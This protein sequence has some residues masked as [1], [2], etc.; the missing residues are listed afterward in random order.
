MFDPLR[1]IAARCTC[2]LLGL[3][4]A[5]LVAPVSASQQG[6]LD[7][8]ARPAEDRARDAGS[9][10]LE[11]F[12]WLGVSPGSTVADLFPGGGYNSHVLAHMVDPGGRVHSVGT[13]ADGERQL[14]ERFAAAGLDNVEIH[15]SLA[16]VSDAS[17]DICVVVRNVHDMLIPEVADQYGMQPDPIF[18]ELRR[19]LKPG[20]I[21]GVIDSRMPGEGIDSDTHRV[22]E[23]LVIAEIEARGFELVDRSE[24]LANP[25]EDLAQPYWDSRF[26]M[27]RMLLKFRKVAS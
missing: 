9:K 20:G 26:S 23:A 3:A 11:V 25:G 15:Q 18:A 27:D 5:I 21:L 10:P 1:N 6:P 4:L 14:G 16:A 2:A 19:S 17:I 12:A 7:D 13:G 22:S 8:P 24:L